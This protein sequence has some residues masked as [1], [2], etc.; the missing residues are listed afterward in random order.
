MANYKLAIDKVLK[1]E[2]GY[3]NDKDDSGGET[4]KG[5]ARNFWPKWSGWKFIDLFEK[6]QGFEKLLSANTNLQ[7]SVIEFYKN[8]FWDKV[9]G[10]KIQSQDIAE[11]LVDSAVNE[12]IVPA[13]KRAQAIVSIPETGKFS[14]ELS[15]ALNNLA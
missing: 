14:E 12:G 1:H 15:N 11:L 10:D 8:N 13:V 3:A 7:D 9:G 4:Y 5:I 2:G 6:K